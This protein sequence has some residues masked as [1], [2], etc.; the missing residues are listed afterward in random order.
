MTKSINKL[1]PQNLERKNNNRYKL[2][3]CADNPY[4]YV[5][6]SS[7]LKDLYD[8]IDIKDKKI[9]SN[10]Q[11]TLLLVQEDASS[12]CYQPL[13]RLF[14]IDNNNKKLL[15]TIMDNFHGY[16]DLFDENGTS[17]SGIA[18][19]C[20]SDNS[21]SRRI[22][23]KDNILAA[24][25]Q[26]MNALKK[27]DVCVGPTIIEHIDYNGKFNSIHRNIFD[28]IVDYVRGVLAGGGDIDRDVIQNADKYM[29]FEDITPQALRK[30]GLLERGKFSIKNNNTLTI[31]NNLINGHVPLL[32]DGVQ[33]KNIAK[34]PLFIQPNTF[35]FKPNAILHFLDGTKLTIERSPEILDEQAH[36]FIK[37]VSRYLSELNK[38]IS[39]SNLNY[40]AKV[41]NMLGK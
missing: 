20:L 17:I 16:Y 5:T 25:V 39:S 6:N 21:S 10:G 24:Q 32:K 33:L 2:N 4:G 34:N 12:C 35:W 22:W 19:N 3:R 14:R 41:I 23:V 13:F 15:G 36:I 29:T 38:L 28:N 8:L 18:A 30:S 40:L 1:Y 37:A 11:E 7:K 9:I 31:N 26:D 27:V